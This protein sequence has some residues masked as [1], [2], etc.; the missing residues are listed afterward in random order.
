M[1]MIL[2]IDLQEVEDQ[3]K[4]YTRNLVEARQ[5]KILAHQIVQQ[6]G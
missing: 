4:E 1:I 2:E 3:I 5:I 6:C